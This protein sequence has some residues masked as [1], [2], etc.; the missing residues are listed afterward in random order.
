MQISE[1][2][3]NHV[4]FRAAMNPILNHVGFR[5]DHEPYM[6]HGVVH[7]GIEAAGFRWSINEGSIA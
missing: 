3:L 4:R 1:C 5:T 2:A 6:V 7:G